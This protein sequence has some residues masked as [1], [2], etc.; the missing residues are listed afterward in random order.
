MNETTS[1]LN[2][3]ERLLLVVTIALIGL[4]AIGALGYKGR[5]HL[6][7]LDRRIDNSEQELINLHTQL[8]QRESVEAAYNQVIA[9]HSTGLSQE[10]VHDSLRREIYRLALKNPDAPEG[11]PENPFVVTIPELREGV[12]RDDGEGYREYQIRFRIPS[13]RFMSALLFLSRVQSSPL[14]LRIDELDMSRP[15]DSKHLS[16]TIQVTRTVLDEVQS[17][18][19]QKG[20]VL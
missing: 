1:K 15:H 11:D 9:E 8:L 5:E 17:E 2:A 18:S 3:R 14:L 12:L 19:T 10:E 6:A 7:M 13:C 20:L 4:F 16:L